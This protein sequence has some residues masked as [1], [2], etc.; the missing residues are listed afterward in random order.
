MMAVYQLHHLLKQSG[1]L[2]DVMTSLEAA[3]SGCWFTLSC[4]YRSVPLLGLVRGW[5]GL[6]ALRVAF[7]APPFAPFG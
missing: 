2:P 1:G 6:L 7:A 3:N 4:R 5:Q